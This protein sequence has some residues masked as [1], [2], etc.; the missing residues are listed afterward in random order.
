MSLGELETVK[1]YHLPLL[2]VVLNDAAYGSELQVLRLWEMDE[3]LAVF[4]PT[5]FTKVAESLGI[6]GVRVDSLDTLDDGPRT[7]PSF[8]TMGAADTMEATA[9]L[10][11]DRLIVALDFPQAAPALDLVDR[12]QGLCCWFKVGLEL[13]LA[14]GNGLVRELRARGCSVFLDLK[15]HDIPNPVAAAVRTASAAG[16]EMLTVHA[17]GG[18]AMLQAAAQAAAALPSAPKLLAVT[19]ERWGGYTREI[20]EHPGAVTIVAVDHEGHVA[21]GR[22]PREATRPAPLRRWNGWR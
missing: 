15:L 5:D 6:R 9:P 19:V 17:S 21:V 3:R 13:Y 2:V 1:R 11:D 12:L 14:E 20:V 22:Q 7:S 18:P 4:P 8:E 10:A 16:A